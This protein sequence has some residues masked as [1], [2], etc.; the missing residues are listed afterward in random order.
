[1][2][3]LN[4]FISLFKSPSAFFHYVS[5]LPFFFFNPPPPQLHQLHWCWCCISATGSS[6]R[7]ATGDIYGTCSEHTQSKPNPTFSV[8]P[9]TW[10]YLITYIFSSS[11]WCTLYWHDM[12]ASH[13]HPYQKKRKKKKKV[14]L[15]FLYYDQNKGRDIVNVHLYDKVTYMYTFLM[16]SPVFPLYRPPY[17][18]ITGSYI[19]FGTCM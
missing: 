3:A 12:P 15:C 6:Q 9:P 7:G 18:M 2:D 4:Q 16:T 5:I 1:M 17:C 14:W 13:T 8:F 11:K 19:L 10:S